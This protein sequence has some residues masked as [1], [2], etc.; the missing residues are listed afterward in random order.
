ML[1]LIADFNK[2]HWLRQLLMQSSYDP[3][4]LSLTFRE[5]QKKEPISVPGKVEGERQALS[6]RVK[7]NTSTERA[8]ML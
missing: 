5:L 6:R 8:L 4:R 3:L 7:V 2:I 1:P